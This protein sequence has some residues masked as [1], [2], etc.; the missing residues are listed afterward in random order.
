MKL[1]RLF[2][3]SF[4]IVFLVSIAAILSYGFLVW[5]VLASMS[6]FGVFGGVIVFSSI[7]AFVYTVASL[8]LSK[9]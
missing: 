9:R 3:S 4:F 5:L 6:Q 7:I 8:L 1:I 2:S